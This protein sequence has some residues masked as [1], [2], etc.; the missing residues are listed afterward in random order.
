[1]SGL[2]LGSGG[3]SM[4]S[5]TG[6]SMRCASLGSASTP[7]VAVT[8]PQ[9]PS[10][11]PGPRH[12]MV[13][14]TRSVSPGPNERSVPEVMQW[15]G[16]P[17]FHTPLSFPRDRS[18]S[19]DCRDYFYTP[20]APL[21]AACRSPVFH[22]SARDSSPGLGRAP[23]PVVPRQQ[24]SARDASPGM[25]RAPVPI[26]TSSAWEPTE[27]IPIVNSHHLGS[28]ASLTRDTLGSP[29]HNLG[30][31]GGRSPPHASGGSS[32]HWTMQPL[33]HSGMP[34]PGDRSISPGGREAFRSIT[35]TLRNSVTPI[36]RSASPAARSAAT[37]RTQPAQSRLLS[38][39]S[40]HSLGAGNRLGSASDH[41]R[42]S[43]SPTPISAAGAASTAPQAMRSSS[44]SSLLQTQ[45]EASRISSGGSRSPRN[46]IVSA[47]P[48]YSQRTTREA[49]PLQLPQ[50]FPAQGFFAAALQESSH[51]TSS[52]RARSS[53]KPRPQGPTAVSTPVTAEVPQTSSKPATS[54]AAAPVD[55]SPALGGRALLAMPATPPQES[56]REELELS[57][58]TTVKIGD[59]TCNITSA[60]GMGSFGAV[61]AAEGPNSLELAVKEIVCHSHAELLN[62]LFE[63]HLLRVLGGEVGNRSP[64]LAKELREAR[65]D[66]SGDA[67][68][69]RDRA[70]AGS[71]SPRGTCAGM[72]P[73]LFAVGTSCIGNDTWR[74]RLGM[75]RI[76]GEPLDVFLEDR[77]RRNRRER[78]ELGG[79]AP[80]AAIVRRQFGEACYYA[81]ELLNQLV[82]AFEQISAVAFHRDVNSHNILIDSSGGANAVPRYGLVDFGLAVDSI[83]WRNE[84]GA[85]PSGNRP[86][87]VGRDGVSTWHYLDVGGDCR[88]WPLSAWM[89]FLAGWRELDACPSL[90]FEYKMQLDLHALGITVM[91]VIAELLPIPPD[92]SVENLENG[93]SGFGG[94]GPEDAYDAL[95]RE[96]WKLRLVWDRYW[97][98]VS[99]LHGR[100]ID[101][102]HNGGDWNALKLDCIT[103]CVHDKLAEDLRLLRMA[104]RE[105]LDACRSAEAVGGEGHKAS[106]KDSAAVPAGASGL[107]AAML[108]LVSDGQGE[109]TAHG[110]HAWQLIGSLLHAGSSGE[111]AV[112]AGRPCTAS[113]STAST[114][115]N[116]EESSSCRLAQD[117]AA[118]AAAADGRRLKQA[119]S[120]PY[121]LLPKPRRVANEEGGGTPRA[122]GAANAGA[123]AWNLGQPAAVQ[124]PLPGTLLRAASQ[125]QLP[126][127]ASSPQC[128]GG[129]LPRAGS[130]PRRNHPPR[131]NLVCK[132]SDL[133]DK[134]DWLAQE[135]AKLGEKREEHSTLGHRNVRK[136]E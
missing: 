3:G 16:Q 107:F 6:S 17:S 88:Y 101:T 47:A 74:V 71:T 36:D 52:I 31:S 96:V 42:T 33:P 58:G 113:C 95:P 78:R 34:R 120:L 122:F 22:P 44:R 39:A 75:T 15:S 89:Q 112:A 104:V 59:V 116:K 40:D 35:S 32:P 136:R 102:F 51:P 125:H 124:A 48:Q 25:C 81:R 72:V 62:A 115:A 67:F 18:M 27:A 87:R 128:G 4:G 114:V 119:S 121:L 29:G 43:V 77:R 23:M 41:A 26:P 70:Q 132:L 57:A 82:P 24:P 126:V 8:T 28:P 10:R 65:G 13:H 66:V 134:V 68:G 46:R 85:A 117:A 50:P 80:S 56:P 90:C 12:R 92:F 100:L 106:S 86:S 135:M 111:R 30:A 64:L 49:A 60:L 7:Q 79:A 1:M 99:P 63:S 76:P 37:L 105:A 73:S 53:S 123:N 108:M 55:A 61:W 20:Q 129:S 91:Q 131:E 45:L 84:E 94:K 93:G 127:A 133:K 38:S 98:R 110:P 14:V 2:G 97:G 69:E 109:E 19:P 118:D 9:A 5:A 83:C 103:S 130:L 21:P 54:A 11:S